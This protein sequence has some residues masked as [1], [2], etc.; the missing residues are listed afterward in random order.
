ML[1]KCCQ[2]SV[3][4]P[5]KFSQNA[6][7]NS[8][9]LQSKCSKHS[10][11]LE[12]FSLFSPRLSLNLALNSTILAKT[13]KFSLCDPSKT[14]LLQI[15]EKVRPTRK[16][17]ASL[18]ANK[19][20]KC[21]EQVFQKQLSKNRRPRNCTRDQSTWQNLAKISRLFFQGNGCG[22][23]LFGVFL[24][25]ERLHKANLSEA[26]LLL[27]NIS[28]FKVKKNPLISQVASFLSQINRCPK[29]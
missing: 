11:T 27:E 28:C 16:C 1:S 6:A 21:T 29:Y 14:T 25:Q 2:N 20:H 5:P 4:M 23:K 7:Q 12:I 22:R 10:Q 18:M 19:L 24:I 15:W 8:V 26:L 17:N 3:K 9:K 13:A